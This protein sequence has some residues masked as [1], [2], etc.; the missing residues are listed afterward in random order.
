LYELRLKAILLCSS[1]HFFEDASSSV[2][3][4]HIGT[5][6]TEDKLGLFA[7]VQIYLYNVAEELPQIEV[8]LLLVLNAKVVAPWS[9]ESFQIVI[10]H[11]VRIELGAAPLMLP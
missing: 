11:W 5:A 4:H 1:T 10:E 7:Q 2:I 6:P 8:I 9:N 3:G